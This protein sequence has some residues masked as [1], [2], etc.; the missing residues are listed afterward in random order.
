[1]RST[2]AHANARAGS[3][4]AAP[5]PPPSFIKAKTDDRTLSASKE[6]ASN[7][8]TFQ[9][10]APDG[11]LDDSHTVCMESKPRVGLKKRASAA[12]EKI[13][14]AILGTNMAAGAAIDKVVEAEKKIASAATEK[15]AEAILGTNMAAGAAIDKL[16]E[17]EKKIASAATE[18]IAEAILSTNMAAGAAVDKIAQSACNAIEYEKKLLRRASSKVVEVEK[19]IKFAGGDD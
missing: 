9:V 15:I 12:T 8:S 4:G 16:V 6:D 11:Q 19:K 3:S 14:E 13:A 10:Y 5:K 17:A 18:K 2:R 7:L 1:V